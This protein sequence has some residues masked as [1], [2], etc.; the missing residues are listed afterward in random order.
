MKLILLNIIQIVLFSLNLLFRGF[1]FIINKFGN[2]FVWI[3]DKIV[4]YG[5]EIDIKIGKLKNKIS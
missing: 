4:D 3:N 5:N 1:I 2:I